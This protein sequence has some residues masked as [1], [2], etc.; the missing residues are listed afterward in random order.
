MPQLPGSPEQEGGAE[1]LPEELLL[2]PAEKTESFF[3]SFPDP[4]S[5]QRSPLQSVDRVRISLSFPQ[6]WQ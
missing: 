3:S 5:G 2:L 6:S 1:P 4:H